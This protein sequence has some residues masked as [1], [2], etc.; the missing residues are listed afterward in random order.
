MSDHHDHDSS[1][2]VSYKGYAIGFILSV[3]LTVIPFAVVMHPTLSHT[4]IIAVI[5]GFAAV[6]VLVHLHYF[7]HMDTSPEQ[8][9]MVTSFVFSALLIVFIIGGSIWI[10]NNLN[11]NTMIMMGN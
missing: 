5:F 4:A 2:G 7:L 3:I 9:D 1:H 6:Q 11:H 8:R 10:M